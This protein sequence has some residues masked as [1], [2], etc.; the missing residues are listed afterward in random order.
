MK[1]KECIDCKQ[2]FLPSGRNQ[3]TCG[4]AS[5]KL[6]CSGKHWLFLATHN[7]DGTRRRYKACRENC[8]SLQHLLCKLKNNTVCALCGTTENITVDHIR[9]RSAD[10][11]DALENLRALCRKCNRNEYHLLVKKALV[12]Y[13]K[14]Q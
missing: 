1:E 7:K 13:Y 6:G 14:R 2:M 3:Q 11:T 9:P 5:K 4:S 12:L 8:R 10:G